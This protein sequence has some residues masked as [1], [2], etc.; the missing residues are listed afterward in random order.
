[1]FG[2]GPENTNHDK[3]LHAKRLP[4]T[5]EHLGHTCHAVLAEETTFKA[6][7]GEKHQTTMKHVTRKRFHAHADVMDKRSMPLWVG[8]DPQNPTVPNIKFLLILGRVQ[9]VVETC[10][11]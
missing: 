2:D 5:F 10:P 3:T 8:D 9:R 4:R 7:L 1:M 6:T 11:V